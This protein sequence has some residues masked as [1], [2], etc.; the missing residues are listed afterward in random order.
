MPGTQTRNFTHID[1]I[2]IGTYLAWKKSKNKEYMIG[3]NKRYSVK[4][5]AKMF[6]A[7]I[8]YL[9]RRPGERYASALSNMNLSNRIYKYYGKILLKDYIGNFINKKK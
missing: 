4:E 9:P 3:T 5:I 1:D 2:V 7:K 8:R 6:N